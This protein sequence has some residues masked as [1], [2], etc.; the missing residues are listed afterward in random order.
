MENHSRKG[1]QKHKQAWIPHQKRMQFLSDISLLKR[2]FCN[3]IMHSSLLQS[4]SRI[5]VFS[6]S[7]FSFIF[8]LRRFAS[9]FTELVNPACSKTCVCSSLHLISANSFYCPLLLAPPPPHFGILS[10]HLSFPPFLYFL[11]FSKANFV[12]SFPSLAYEYIYMH[13]YE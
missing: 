6:L 8:L 12:S 4:T 7:P 2:P 13:I 1:L 9:S 10:F 5:L 3:V 11:S